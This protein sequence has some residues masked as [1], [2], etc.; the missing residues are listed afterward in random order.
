MCRGA[1]GATGATAG[2]AGTGPWTCFFRLDIFW[3]T[4]PR[5]VELLTGATTFFP[6]EG[7]DGLFPREDD[8]GLFL[9]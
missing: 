5:L 1:T 8:E 6:R 3:D 9:L 4:V 2:A 7:D